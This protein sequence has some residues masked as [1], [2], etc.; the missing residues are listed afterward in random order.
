MPRNSQIDEQISSVLN[1]VT[2]KPS[3]ILKINYSSSIKNNFDEINYENLSAELKINNLETSFDY[4]N[5]NDLN[6]NSYLSNTTSFKLDDSNSLSFKTRRNKKINLTEYYTLSYQYE[7]DCLSASIQYNK[8]FYA[9]RDIKPDEGIFLKF[10]IIPD[11]KKDKSKFII[12][13]FFMYGNN[14]KSINNHQ[15]IFLKNKN[16]INYK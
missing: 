5:Q 9:D 16:Y 1:E 12:K 13:N 10:T 11:D 15:F 3:N 8:E 7:N 14:F 2:F 4:S 6:D